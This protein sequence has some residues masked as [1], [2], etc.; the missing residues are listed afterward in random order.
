MSVVQ[1][2]SSLLLQDCSGCPPELLQLGRTLSWPEPGDQHPVNT[3]FMKEE[4]RCNEANIIN[5]R[6]RVITLQ[7]LTFP[8]QGF[9]AA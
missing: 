3:S 4:E 7:V 5:N 8:D 9:C 2:C 1:A 6:N